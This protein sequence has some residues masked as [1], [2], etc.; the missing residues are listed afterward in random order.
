VDNRQSVRVA[1][2]TSQDAVRAA[3]RECE[4]LGEEAFLYEYGF[5]PAADLVVAID[6]RRYP[7]EALLAAAHGHQ[8]PNLG[9]L[10]DSDFHG[11]T[12]ITTKLQELGFEVRRGGADD[13]ALLVTE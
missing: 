10:A 8:Y 9:P 13:G 2:V 3:A 4:A 7:A 5:R 12:E 11:A 1:D 6:G